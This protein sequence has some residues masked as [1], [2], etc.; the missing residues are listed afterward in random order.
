MLLPKQTVQKVIRGI[1]LLKFQSEAPTVTVDDGGTVIREQFIDPSKLAGWP[2]E[3]DLDP[4]N[5]PNCAPHVVLF[6]RQRGR[7]PVG[8]GPSLSREGG[9]GAPCSAGEATMRFYRARIVRP[10]IVDK[11]PPA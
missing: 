8:H 1:P 10:A 3:A 5:I 7:L 11:G 9:R 4:A 2:L 6:P